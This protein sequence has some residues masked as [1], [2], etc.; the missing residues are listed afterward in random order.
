MMTMR[1]VRVLAGVIAMVLAVASAAPA[2]AQPA[3]DLSIGFG[4]GLGTRPGFQLSV[5]VKVTDEVALACRAGGIVHALG[6]GCGAHLYVLGDSAAYVVL[7]YGDNGVYSHRAG[8]FEVRRVL[9]LGAGFDLD[10]TAEGHY[11]VHAGPSL[12]IHRGLAGPRPPGEPEGDEDRD[13]DDDGR[14]TDARSKRPGQIGWSFFLDA[15][16]RALINVFE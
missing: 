9:N 3:G 13:D 8:G 7:E 16:A 12:T 6:R 10:R 5:E 4:F 14:A 2:V 15:G 1:P 11:Y